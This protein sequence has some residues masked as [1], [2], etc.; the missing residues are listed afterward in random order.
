[1]DYIVAIQARPVT[2]PR[3]RWTTSVERHLEQFPDPCT[4]RAALD[5]VVDRLGLAAQE[6]L[7]FDIRVQI[8][9]RAGADTPDA[10]DVRTGY[11]FADTGAQARRYAAELAGTPGSPVRRDD[12][13][14]GRAVFMLGGTPA[15]LPAVPAPDVPAATEGAVPAPGAPAA[16]TTVTPTGVAGRPF[17]VVPGSAPAGVVPATGEWTEPATT[18]PAPV[19]AGVGPRVWTRDSRQPGPDV[20]RIFDG[21]EILVRS[22]SDR[23]APA[24]QGGPGFAWSE[25]PAALRIDATHPLDRTSAGHLVARRPIAVRRRP[26]PFGVNPGLADLVDV[27]PAFTTTSW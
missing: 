23:W 18:E 11:R 14:T 5:R 24:G 13:R 21:V 25:I 2:L 7:D 8:F 1:M 26:V 12:A 17:P 22:A 10:E 6:K 3:G 16:G 19:T 15:W 27:S 20:T 4:P 9:T